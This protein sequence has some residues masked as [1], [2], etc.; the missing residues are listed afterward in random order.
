M[1]LGVVMHWR[2]SRVGKA[3]ITLNLPSEIYERGSADQSRS[4]PPSRQVLL[5][6]SFCPKRAGFVAISSNGPEAEDAV[7]VV[8]L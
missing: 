3:V 4:L 6:L 5:R 8:V 1:G 7:R 2:L